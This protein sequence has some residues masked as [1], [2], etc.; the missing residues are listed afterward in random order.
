MRSRTLSLHLT[1][2]CFVSYHL[3]NLANSNS[4]LRRDVPHTFHDRCEWTI[5]LSPVTFS[6]QN[7]GEF[8]TL[9]RYTSGCNIVLILKLQ[10]MNVF[11][12]LPDFVRV[13]ESR[14]GKDELIQ[15]YNSY[16][17]L[18]IVIE[19]YRQKFRLDSVR[20]F[21]S[22]RGKNELIYEYNSCFILI[23]V[24]KYYRQKLRLDF[25]RVFESRRGKMN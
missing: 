14:R 21:E 6:L 15:E 2:S 1:L 25:V 17:I 19:Y 10:T 22:R 20:V 7:N 24:T 18:I 12:F 4:V 11:L 9:Q 8:L 16:F 5:P 3:L 23:L 13:F